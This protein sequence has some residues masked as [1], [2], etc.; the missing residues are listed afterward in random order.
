M[1]PFLRYCHIYEMR[2]FGHG[3]FQEVDLIS[4]HFCV[5]EQAEHY[6]LSVPLST[7]S[8]SQSAS[9]HTRV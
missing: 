2:M 3:T 8:I 1:V 6:K 5:A 9:V 7:G 4:K